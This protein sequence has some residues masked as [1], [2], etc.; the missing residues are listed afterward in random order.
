MGNLG[1]DGYQHESN[2]TLVETMRFLDALIRAGRRYDLLLLPDQDR[3]LERA[4]RT[5][6]LNAVRCYFHEH[7][8][9]QWWR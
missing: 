4:T 6:I 5:Y 2:L 3:H 1:Q 7:L 8:K 9:L